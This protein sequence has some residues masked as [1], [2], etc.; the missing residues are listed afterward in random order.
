MG[1]KS[2]RRQGKLRFYD[3]P[4]FS[5]ITAM[6]TNVAMTGTGVKTETVLVG[7]PIYAGT[8]TTEGD[9][10]FKAVAGG[11]LSSSSAVVTFAL[12][13]GT[14]AI[15]TVATTGDKVKEAYKPFHVEFD[16]RIVGLHAS[17]GQI[18]A[19]GVNYIGYSTVHVDF[20]GTTGS[21]A[22]GTKFATSDLA[23][24][25]GA[26]AGLNITADF[27]DTGGGGAGTTHQLHCTYGYI[28][29]YS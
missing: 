10:H 15:M 18:A 9:M 21:T 29:Y 2:H 14:T 4:M 20:G 13:W 11:I 26:T 6:S 12:N 17:S 25:A 28:R 5:S 23:L 19:V 1:T 7:G 24:T 8:F 3:K 22:S 27:D 16:G